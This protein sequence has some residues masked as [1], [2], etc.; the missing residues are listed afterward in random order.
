VA[1]TTRDRLLEAAIAVIE[2]DGEQAVKV[3]D[4]ATRAGVTEPSIYHYFGDRNGLIE[5]AQ[6]IR[7]GQGQRKILEDFASAAARCRNADQFLAL[8]RS[9]L[10]ASYD[11][12]GAQR[13]L[14]RVNVIGSAAARPSL[15]KQLANQQQLS[16]ELLGEALAIAQVRGF[17]RPDLNCEMFAA[18]VIGMGTGRILIEL[19]PA[20]QGS[21]EWNALAVDA[22]LALL[23][24]PP[25]SLT[26]WAPDGS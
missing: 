21:P 2:A 11:S 3:H 26:D 8:V 19:D 20:T 24:H 18:W 23:G 22:V 14:A 13:R 16:N 5:H 15:T 1:T 4:I 25:E 7:F 9:L 17:I 6:A 12:Q 10:V